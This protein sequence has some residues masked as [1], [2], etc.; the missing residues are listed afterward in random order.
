MTTVTTTNLSWSASWFQGAVPST[1]E[2]DQDPLQ[3]GSAVVSDASESSGTTEGSDPDAVSLSGEAATY[4][5]TQSTQIGG[6]TSTIQKVYDTL[7]QIITNSSTSDVQKWAA[8]VTSDEMR[9]EIEA[10][11]GNAANGIETAFD[12]ETENTPF[13]QT[14][15]AGLQDISKRNLTYDDNQ[16][17]SIPMERSL[18]YLQQ[19]EE[20]TN[21]EEMWG[22]SSLSINIQETTIQTDAGAQTSFTLSSSFS[23]Q[24][25]ILP[26]DALPT[27]DTSTPTAVPSQPYNFTPEGNTTSIVGHFDNMDGMNAELEKEIVDELFASPSSPTSS[28]SDTNPTGQDSL[29]TPIPDKQD[30]ENNKTTQDT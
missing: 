16:P 11:G 22:S 10:H 15:N 19:T 12:Q 9:S 26:T 13:M 6:S 27:L 24:E 14:I 5:N 30:T 28:A 29:N 21:E 8:Y 17:V 7:A 1:D 25:N 18:L 3:H 23:G 4:L 2:K 20:R